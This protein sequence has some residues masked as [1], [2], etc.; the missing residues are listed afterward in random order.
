MNIILTK[1]AK[2]RM[3]ERE[4]KFENIQDT[5]N[6]S[7]YTIK[8]NGKV[9]AFKKINEKLLKVIY[10]EKGKFIKIVTLIWR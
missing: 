6:F 7:D 10:I 5:I 2:Q 9:E 3:L 1:H 8:K 4:I